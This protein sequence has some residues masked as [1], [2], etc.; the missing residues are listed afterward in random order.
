MSQ[1]IYIDGRP[2][3]IE[4]RDGGPGGGGGGI[5]DWVAYLLLGLFLWFDWSHDWAISG[6]IWLMVKIG[7]YLMTIGFFWADP[8]SFGI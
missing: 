4:I 2:T 3:G 1:H 6:F 7:A 5:P 8:A